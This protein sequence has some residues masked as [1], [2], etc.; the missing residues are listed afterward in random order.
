MP[1][2][3]LLLTNVDLGQA[4]VFLGVAAAL[5]QSRSQVEIHFA[6]FGAL[7]SEVHALG[8]Q[9]HQQLHDVSDKV[10][11]VDADADDAAAAAAD[12]APDVTD[13]GAGAGAAGVKLPAL[14]FHKIEGPAMR[15][16]LE[17][18]TKMSGIATTVGHW[19]PQS[20]LAPLGTKNTMRA[21][22]DTTV[23]FIPYHGPQLGKVYSSIVDIIA[24]VSPDLVLV[25]GLMTAGLTACYH[26]HVNFHI[27]SPNSIREFAGPYQP[28]AAGLWK[29]PAYV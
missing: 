24:T 27:L 11:A 26:L 21:I 10:A 12:A 18:Q 14:Y 29:F 7:E 4:N 13:A 3:L 28:N 22:R 20:Y 23:V 5:L 2:K 25:D 19:L 8:Q 1:K 17:R 16:G 15:E 6:T 9:L